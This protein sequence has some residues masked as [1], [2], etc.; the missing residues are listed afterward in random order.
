MKN[1]PPHLF[2]TGTETNVGK[3]VITAA[4]AA[5]A[6]GTVGALKPLASG[7][8]LGRPGSDALLL[9]RAAGHEPEER[10]TW[11]APL[12]PHRAAILEN[13]PAHLGETLAWI[14]EKNRGQLLVEGVGG[15]RVPIDWDWG[16][17]DL[18]KGLGYPILL[19]A[20]NRL[21]VLNHT[22]LTVD[23]IR[24]AGLQCMG[25]VLNQAQPRSAVQ[26]PS[27][28]YNLE[29]LQ[30]LLPHLPVT[31]FPHLASLEREALA[32]AGHTLRQA[33]I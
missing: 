7:V 8:A 16:I 9:G 33:L 19:V 13:K 4:L 12:S 3:S 21:G 29:D 18:A 20:A 22:L 2:I 23:A 5:S 15:W 10:Y 11:T 14:R 31:F 30:N 27:Q 6:I 17:P 32:E 1:F 25:I 28:R 24:H 26:E